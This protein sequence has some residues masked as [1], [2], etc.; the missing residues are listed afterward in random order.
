MAF[1]S[2]DKNQSD[3]NTLS[4]RRA[5]SYVKKKHLAEE[6]KHLAMSGTKTVMIMHST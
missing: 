1:F 4:E 6:E 2:H 5:S 3:Q